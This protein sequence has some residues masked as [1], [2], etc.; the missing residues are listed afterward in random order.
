M[1]FRSRRVRDLLAAEW[2]AVG[3]SRL[4]LAAEQIVGD[5]AV[6]TWRAADETVRAKYRILGE[7]SSALA[8]KAQHFVGRGS[9]TQ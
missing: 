3:P 8:N 5:G 2:A 1:L 7:C 9:E 6:E 4:E